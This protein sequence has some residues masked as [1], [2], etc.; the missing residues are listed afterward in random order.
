[1]T[2]ADPLPAVPSRPSAAPTEGAPPAIVEPVEA[3]ALREREVL[4]RERELVLREREVAI[5]E[6]TARFTVLPAVAAILVAAVTVLVNIW[7]EDER[8]ASAAL[9]E[10]QRREFNLVLEAARLESRDAAMGFLRPFVEAGLV[11]KGVG[12][13]LAEPSRLPLYPDELDRAPSV[14]GEPLIR[15]GVAHAEGDPV[16]LWFRGDEVGTVRLPGGGSARIEVELID[17][18]SR[19]VRVT[20]RLIGDRTAIDAVEGR[21]GDSLRFSAPPPVGDLTVTVMDVVPPAV[22][23]PA[24]LSEVP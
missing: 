1:M 4:A 22:D 19:R 24:A 16:V 3:R 18:R 6:W 7:L 14:G 5:K 13:L 2:A 17:A 11:S 9:Q 12:D 8:Q 23:L 21:E 10:R 20:A 15:L